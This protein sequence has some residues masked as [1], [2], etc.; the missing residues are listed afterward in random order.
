MLVC[1]YMP[2]AFYNNENAFVD[3]SKTWNKRRSVIKIKST[4]KRS[5]GYQK[6]QVVVVNSDPLIRASA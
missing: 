2:D 6:Q 5:S 3:V 4:K 1:N